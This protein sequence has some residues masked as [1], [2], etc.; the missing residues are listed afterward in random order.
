MGHSQVALQRVGKNKF[1]VIAPSRIIYF[2]LNKMIKCMHQ[3]GVS[4]ELGLHFWR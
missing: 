4:T 3:L 1:K 2:T